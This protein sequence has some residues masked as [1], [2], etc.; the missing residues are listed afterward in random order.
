MKMTSH[1][2][3]PAPAKRVFVSGAGIAMTPIEGAVA[4][5][6]YLDLFDLRGPVFSAGINY[7][8]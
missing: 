4:M 6:N 1:R 8:F 5:R 3:A 2:H 7:W